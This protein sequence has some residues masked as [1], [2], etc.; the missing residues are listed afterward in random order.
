MCEISVGV[1]IVV[2]CL[3]GCRL[4]RGIAVK[5]SVVVDVLIKRPLLL[6][7]LLCAV[8]NM[9]VLARTL[10]ARGTWH[11]RGLLREQRGRGARE[12]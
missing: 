9:A 5:R 2:V 10:V 7:L 12:R 11:E 4:L 3:G 1:I 6:L 8:A